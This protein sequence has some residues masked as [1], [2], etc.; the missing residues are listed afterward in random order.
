MI[1]AGAPDTWEE[2]NHETPL[3]LVRQ[4]PVIKR[5][6]QAYTQKVGGL[7]IESARPGGSQVGKIKW[8]IP[9]F[10]ASG[11]VLLVAEAGSGKT[12]IIY[13]AA[14]A[15][16]EGTLFL[17]QIQAIHGNVL[18]IQ[19]DETRLTAE[20]KFR[21]MSLRAEFS[22]TYAEPP[23]DLEALEQIIKSGEYSA[24]IIDSVTSLLATDGQE[25]TD[26]SFVRKMYRINKI[27]EDN[28]VLAIIAAH[29]NKPQ[30]GQQRRIVTIHDISGRSGIAAAVTDIW[31]LW[32]DTQPRWENHFNM[33]CLGKRNCKIDQL[34]MLQGSEEDYYW[35]IKET[36]DGLLP[37][38][39]LQ[40]TFKIQEFLGKEDQDLKL[41]Q[42]ASGVSTTYE[43]ARRICSDLYD[44]GLITRI[45]VKQSG[46]GRPSY[47][48]GIF[49]T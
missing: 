36:S 14:E 25:T 8:T 12:S 4:L 17:D 48:Y 16:Q 40:L 43:V 10:A 32:R 19:G 15:I 33:R 13:R 39:K 11:I 1:N 31:A 30:D 2:D 20:A 46:R 47:L 9:G 27:S 3:E 5:H 44:Q 38:Q 45:P 29:L 18:V 34:W 35:E 28:G 42:I 37:L 23:L 22:I 24:I 26:D 7:Q 49:P 6:P 41:E 21:K